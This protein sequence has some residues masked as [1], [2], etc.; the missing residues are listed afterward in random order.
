M[1]KSQNIFIMHSLSSLITP[2]IVKIDIKINKSN[3]KTYCKSCIKV[4]GKEKKHKIYFPNK[5]NQIIYYFKKYT[6]F[7]PK[8]HQKIL[9]MMYI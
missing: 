9:K 1:A 8:Q 6:N 3:F 4:L 7:L 2:Y 5:K